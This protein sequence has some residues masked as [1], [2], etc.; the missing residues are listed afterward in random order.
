MYMKSCALHRLYIK[1]VQCTSSPDSQK[2]NE[3]DQEIPQS[4]TADQPRHR[5]EEPENIYS[6]KTSKR[7]KKQSNQLSLPR[8]DDCKTRKDKK[9]CIPN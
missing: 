4:H 6:N 5:E 8:Q 7:P 1:P 9:Q 3:Y 2:A